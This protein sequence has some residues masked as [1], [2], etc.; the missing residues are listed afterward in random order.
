M[1][2]AKALDLV[3]AGSKGYRRIELSVMLYDDDPPFVEWTVC[4][5]GM[6]FTGKTLNSAVSQ[7][8]DTP[9]DPNTLD[10]LNDLVPY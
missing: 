3:R 1:T 2:I 10:D 6:R 7:A 9:T 5:H 8:V 4:A